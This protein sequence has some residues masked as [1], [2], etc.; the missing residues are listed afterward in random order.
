MVM[1]M[2]T[3]AI[4]QEAPTPQDPARCVT[5]QYLSKNRL[6]ARDRAR[7]AAGIIGGQIKVQNLTVRQTAKL[8]RVS[9]KY[10]GA[11]RRPPPAPESLAEHF[12]RATPAEW[13]EAARTIGAAAVW[14]RMI[15]PLF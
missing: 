4:Y 3:Q 13:L 14:D 11:V 5:G 8:C 2:T 7:L 12:V 9:E 10:V 15:V 6:S 1:L